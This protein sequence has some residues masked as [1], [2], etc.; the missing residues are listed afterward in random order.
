LA[1]DVTKRHASFFFPV[2]E[3]LL[4][5]LGAG[6]AEST[7]ILVGFGAARLRLSRSAMAS[8]KPT[9]L[10]ARKNT[11]VDLNDGVPDFVS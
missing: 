9:G 11:G 5:Y 7:R 10:A 1:W 4:A 6:P 8:L 3:R 2:P